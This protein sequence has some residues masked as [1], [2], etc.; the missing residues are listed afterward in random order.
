MNIK[1]IITLF[2]IINVSSSSVSFAMDDDIHDAVRAADLARVQ[3][4]L[5]A[6][7]GAV[8]ARLGSFR[9]TPLHVAAHYG[10]EATAQLLLQYA[11]DVDARDQDD[12]TPLHRTARNGNETIASLLLE[13][14]ADVNAQDQDDET[15]LHR[16][17]G[18]ANEAIVRVLLENCADA[19]ARDRLFG[20]PLHH[21]AIYGHVDVVQILLQ[22]NA[23]AAVIPYPG[24]L[25]LFKPFNNRVS[26][27]VQLLR[28]WPLYK[29]Y[30]RRQTIAF[31]MS[32]HTRLGQC[33][34]ARRLCPDLYVRILSL[35]HQPHTLAEIHQMAD[36]ERRE[37]ELAAQSEGERRN[38]ALSYL[39][40]GA[41]ATAVATVAFFAYRFFKRR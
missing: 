32:A 29:A 24:F 16:A 6:N 19:N 15:P 21:A 27:C 4:I 36:Q 30:M 18:N 14:R 8:H 10:N 31:A 22:H 40:G 2:L 7:P 1:K 9:I 13:H 20:A 5:Q 28:D 34:F 37:L 3:Q 25:R 35:V 41:A 33:S 11:A 23:D 12:E 17:A 26:T 38:R 39:G